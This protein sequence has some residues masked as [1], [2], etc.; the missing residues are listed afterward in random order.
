M[1]K[2][3]DRPLVAVTMGDPAGVGPEIVAK[4]L[5]NPEGYKLVRPLVVG[6]QW[7]LEQAQRWC[8]L[9][10]EIRSISHPADGRYVHNIVDLLDVG[11]A[12]VGSIRVGRVQAAAGKAAFDYLRRA[13]DLALAGEVEAI[14]TAPINKEALRAA[15]VPFIDHTE[16][17]A[18]LTQS[19]HPLTIFLVRNLRIFFLTRHVSLAQA[20][21]Q[22]TRERVLSGLVEVDAA[23]ERFGLAHARI[24]VAALN[25]HAGEGGIFGDEEMI[26][27]EPAVRDARDM[28]IDA[29]GPIPAD[30]V[31][32][33][34]LTGQFDAVLSLYHDQ[35]HIAAKTLDFERTVAITAGLPFM[36]SSVDHGT[37]FDIAGRGIASAISMEEA[38]RAAG[39]Y[40]KLVRKRG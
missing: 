17:L 23:L 31:F 26:E 6:D 1:Q 10:S 27:V 14:A 2:P 29:H 33:L 7:V 8:G 22:I 39:E 21:R 36:R 9:T 35:G 34:A 40:A 32:H 37:A 24:A 25:P 4:A 11:S 15:G 16:A 38:I 13:I 19:A 5:A 12:E 20:C 30:A 18:G 3:K 28:G